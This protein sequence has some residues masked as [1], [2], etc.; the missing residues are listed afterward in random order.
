MNPVLKTNPFCRS[1]MEVMIFVILLSG[2]ISGNKTFNRSMHPEQLYISRVLTQPGEFTE[3]I[4]GPAW[5]P[6]GNLYAVNYMKQGTIGRVT[7]K[8]ECSLFVE[9]PAGS[10]GN[11]IRFKRDGSMFIADYTKHNILRVELQTRKISIYAHESQMNQP[12]DLAISAGGKLFASDPNWKDNTGNLWRIDLDG[13]AVLLESNMGTTNG[14]E[15]SP[16][17]KILYVN[18]SVQRNIWAYDLS[19]EGE[20]SGKRL[21]IQFSDFGMDGMR[22]DVEGNLYVTRF[23]KGT[24]VKLSPSGD[25]LKE[26]YLTGKKP[27]N[28]AFGGQDGRTCFVTLHDNGNIEMFRADLPG[29][30]WVLINRQ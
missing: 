22:C 18:E 11:G 16:D 7:K 30:S 17:E 23:G 2:C 4:E 24:I 19:P 27:T 12:N 28:I 8:G 10:I 13:R 6:D 1:V 3:G 5:G 29:R 9:L 20:V 21:L 14:V 25:I 15:V 26:I